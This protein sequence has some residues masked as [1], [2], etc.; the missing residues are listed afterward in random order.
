MHKAARATCSLNE[1][2]AL[3]KKAARGV[4]YAWGLSEEAGKA[5]RWLNSHGLAGTEALT[6]LLMLKD[7]APNTLTAPTNLDGPWQAASHGLLC[8]LISG[9]A[10]ND[11]ADRI[12]QEHPV[13][14]TDM[15]HPVLVV[16]FAAWA[17]LHIGCPVVVSWQD[18][19]MATDGYNLWING[20]AD[21]AGATRADR[22][23][24][25][26]S[27]SKQHRMKAPEL[28]GAVTAHAWDSL[29]GFA[30]RTY[31]PATEASRL[32]GAGAGTSDN[33]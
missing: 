12:T 33:D 31:A 23:I 27:A 17:A 14:M 7:T 21:Q 5:V 22:V 19:Q 13:Q 10:L 11:F 28:R 1:I 6:A 16:P 29:H 2:E 32:R 25:A 24:C 18:V 30:H 20:P 3:S 4:G 15:A 26:V 9:A 8:P